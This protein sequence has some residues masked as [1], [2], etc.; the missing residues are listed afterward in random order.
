MNWEHWVENDSYFDDLAVFGMGTL[1]PGGLQATREL[2]SSMSW[3]HKDVLDVGC[4]NGTTLKL[5]QSFGAR[6]TGIESSEYMRHSAVLG[7]VDSQMIIPSTIE[8]VTLNEQIYDVILLEG[9]LGFIQDPIL[10]ITKL[11]PSM[12]ENGCII[13]CDWIPHQR[14]INNDYDFKIFAKT[15]PYSLVQFLE[16]Y[17]LRCTIRITNTQ[18]QVFR[19]SNDEAV[20][21]AWLFFPY[22]P[23]AKLQ[24]AVIR[25]LS[26]MKSVLNET[27]NCQR[28]MLAAARSSQYL[29]RF[30]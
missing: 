22:A 2:I 29:P 5:L 21:L 3:H 6:V 23:V 16:T 17:D 9:V 19:I 15:D 26:L 20:R 25:K 11:I 28:Y 27:I 13:I 30:Q 7:G 8:V 1:H 4:G 18:A 10:V 14:P 24:A 12:R